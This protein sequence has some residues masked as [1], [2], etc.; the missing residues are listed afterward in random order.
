LVAVLLQIKPYPLLPPCS[1][2]KEA[3]R[4]YSIGVFSPPCEGGRLKF[5]PACFREAALVT[6]VLLM[7]AGCSKTDDAWQT[8][9]RTDTPDAYEA[10]LERNPASKY[11]TQARTRRDALIDERDWSVARRENSAASYAKYLEAHPDGVWSELAAQRRDQLKTE[12]AAPAVAPAAASAVATMPAAPTAVPVAPVSAPPAVAAAPKPPTVRTPNHYLQL[13][14]FSSASAAKR[15]WGGLQRSFVELAELEP[16]IDDTPLRGSSLYR[17]RV[18]V[19]SQEEA[20]RICAALVRGGAECIK[21][22][23]R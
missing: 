3:R 10:F 7:L 20:D 12:V 9:V 16:I 15:S 4:E 18:A 22:K 2:Q 19:A 1:R 23:S 13:G 5:V 8:A 6:T 11:A 14:A 17:L 21:S